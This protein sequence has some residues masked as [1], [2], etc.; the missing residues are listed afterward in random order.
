MGNARSLPL[1]KDF[2][3]IRLDDGALSGKKGSSET[4][5]V[6]GMPV[7]GVAQN[8]IM[9]NYRPSPVDRLPWLF[10]ES[11]GRQSADTIFL[12]VSGNTSVCSTSACR[13]PAILRTGTKFAC[14]GVVVCSDCTDRSCS[15][16][17][18]KLRLNLRKDLVG[19]GRVLEGVECP[20]CCASVSVGF[21][22]N[23]KFKQIL[24]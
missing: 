19:S 22:L 18:E 15:E 17:A 5:D 1:A 14:C 8:L 2:S 6:S 9:D 3:R 12:N 20:A 10:P 23:H 13:S 24:M 16:V 21:P 7:W 4:V 11:G